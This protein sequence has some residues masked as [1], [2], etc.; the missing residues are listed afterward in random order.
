MLYSHYLPKKMS[1]KRKTRKEESEEKN[2]RR[3]GKGFF[4]FCRL[5]IFNRIELDQFI[6]AKKKQKTHFRGGKKDSIDYSKTLK[7]TIIGAAVVKR[8]LHF[9]VI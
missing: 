8:Q 4:Y 9:S 3:G 1:L 5:E 6:R 7:S 2:K